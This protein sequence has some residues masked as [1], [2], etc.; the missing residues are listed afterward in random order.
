MSTTKF[1]NRFRIPSARFE[2][3]D[4]NGGL[5]FITICT[6]NREHFFVKMVNCV[7]FIAP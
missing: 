1:Q 4:Y 3:H 7:K 5:Y 6:K 2:H